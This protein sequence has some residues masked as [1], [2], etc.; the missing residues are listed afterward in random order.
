M[1]MRAG[2]YF[3]N[4]TKLLLKTSFQVASHNFIFLQI[5]TCRQTAANAF[6]LP[7]SISPEAAV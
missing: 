7:L 4:Y 2:M 6:V 3:K 1:R 5:A